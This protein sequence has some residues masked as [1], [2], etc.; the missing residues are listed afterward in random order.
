MGVTEAGL[1][2]KPPEP[3]KEHKLY[4]SLYG[5]ELAKPMRLAWKMLDKVSNNEL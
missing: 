4:I 2:P 3:K 1:V 5:K